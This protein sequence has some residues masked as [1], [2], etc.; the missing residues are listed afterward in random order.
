[1]STDVDKTPKNLELPDNGTGHAPASSTGGAWDPKRPF[2]WIL[3]QSSAEGVPKTRFLRPRPRA[4]KPPVSQLKLPVS[5]SLQ[6]PRTTPVATVVPKSSTAAGQDSFAIY[7]TLSFLFLRFSFLHD[8]I[9]AHIGFN[10][11]LLTITGLLAYIGLFKAT[12]WRAASKSTLF[13]AWVVFTALLVIGLP[14]SSWP[15]GSFAVVEPFVK[16][17]FICLPLIAGLFYTW[18]RLRLLFL[19]LAFAGVAVTLITFIS[20]QIDINGRLN[21][22]FTSTIGNPNDLAAHLIYVSIFML[23]A[24]FSLTRNIAVRLLFL[25]TTGLALF[26]ILRTG[27]RGAFLGLLCSVAIGFLAGNMKTR[28]ALLFAA[29]IAALILLSVMPQSMTERLTTFS[30]GAGDEAK[31]SYD[32]RRYLLERSIEITFEHPIFGVGAAQFSS[33]EGAEAAAEGHHHAHWQET[34]NTFTEVSSEDGIPA[35]ICVLWGIGGSFALFWRLSKRANRDS[36]LRQFAMPAYILV[37]GTAGICGSLF[38]VNF[39]YKL[40]LVVLTGIAIGV[41]R[42]IAAK[43]ADAGV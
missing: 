33:V 16:D 26:Q 37:T 24:A 43:Q 5:A 13:W 12:T 40:Y 38:F 1:M 28:S 14:L 4:P 34:H 2:G 7:A 25:G 27:S 15:G 19:T 22:Y 23:V 8:F 21:L 42:A 30:G 3:P 20:G 18:D 41:Q 39:A 31:E 11:Y 10:S 29:P 35:L 36:N 6:V 9:T 17:N 32:A